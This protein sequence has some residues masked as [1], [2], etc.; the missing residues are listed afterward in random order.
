MVV[1]L[2]V[3]S[4]IILVVYKQLSKL[5]YFVLKS[6]NVNETE[7]SKTDQMKQSQ[8]LCWNHWLELFQESLIEI[9]DLTFVNVVCCSKY[10]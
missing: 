1:D 9:M 10:E 2:I 5:Q 6:V 3:R 4:G 8:L 7:Y